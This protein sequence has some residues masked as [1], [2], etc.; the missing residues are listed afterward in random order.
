MST[1]YRISS[2][3][4]L[5]YSFYIVTQLDPITTAWILIL[6]HAGMIQYRFNQYS[7]FA[8]VQNKIRCSKSPEKRIGGTRLLCQSRCAYVL[9]WQAWGTAKCW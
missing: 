6:M 4:G 9:R 3:I 8:M 1:S 7:V 2:S 5:A